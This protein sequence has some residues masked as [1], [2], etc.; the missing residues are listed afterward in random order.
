MFKN[1]KLL[2]YLYVDKK[3]IN[4]NFAYN[5]IF[6]NNSN[7][8]EYCFEILNNDIFSNYNFTSDCSHTCFQRDST[9]INKI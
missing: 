7:D 5:N 6:D 2:I 9:I 3:S 8:T 4:Q 1:C